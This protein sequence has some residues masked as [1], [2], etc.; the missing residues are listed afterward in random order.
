MTYGTYAWDFI[1]NY[2]INAKPIHVLG[3]LTS[4]FFFL[5]SMV[6]Y[7]FKLT[8]YIFKQISR[9]I[10]LIKYNCKVVIQ[11]HAKI[12]RLL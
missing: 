6:K 7:K 8:K 2:N 4:F 3:I 12:L 5:I 1:C 10:T 11:C 9:D